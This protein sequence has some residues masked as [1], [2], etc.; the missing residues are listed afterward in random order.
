MKSAIIPVGIVFFL[1]LLVEIG[2]YL[3]SPIPDWPSSDVTIVIVG[4]VGA[5]VYGIRWGLAR[6]Q[7]QG[8]DREE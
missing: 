8:A 1:S 6:H 5:L 3:T 7:N 2:L 4:I